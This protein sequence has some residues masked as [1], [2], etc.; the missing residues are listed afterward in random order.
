M[1]GRPSDKPFGHQKAQRLQAGA[2]LA[3]APIGARKSQ[4]VLEGNVVA[5]FARTGTVRA[6]IEIQRA[7]G[8]RSQGLD[9]SLDVG[10]SILDV[11]RSLAPELLRAPTRRAQ[12]SRRT[13]EHSFA[14]HDAA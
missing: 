12:R 2:C 5:L 7:S 1:T 4:P 10:C 11:R 6:A 13:S 9:R 3:R 8:P 14:P